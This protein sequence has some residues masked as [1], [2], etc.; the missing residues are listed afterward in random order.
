MSRPRRW[1]I[2]LGLLLLLA[3]I[4]GFTA[5]GVFWTAA[6]CPPP[7]HPGCTHPTPLNVTNATIL[8]VGAIGST[9]TMVTGG[10]VLFIATYLPDVPTPSSTNLAI[11]PEV[12]PPSRAHTPAD[13]LT[14][15]HE[16][17][18]ED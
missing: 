9:G 13:S 14:P 4:I 16:T 11:N 8:L 7:G 3:G 5:V 2:I 12:V 17:S 18:V 6:V 15:S 10:I 1:S